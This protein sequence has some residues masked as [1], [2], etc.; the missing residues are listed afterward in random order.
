LIVLYDG[1]KFVFECYKFCEV[2][3]G[4]IMDLCLYILRQ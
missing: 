4:N 3:V 1:N 2:N